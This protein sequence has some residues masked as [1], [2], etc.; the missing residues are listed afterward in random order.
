[1][2]ILSQISLQLLGFTLLSLSLSRHYDQ[3]IN[4]VK[5]PSKPIVW[6][7]RLSGYGILLLAIIQGIKSWGLA[8]GLV[9]SFATATLVATLLAM[10]LTYKPHYLTFIFVRLKP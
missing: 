6:T 1:M 9:Y 4:S 2:E 10:L 7:L 3:V 5:R 8:L